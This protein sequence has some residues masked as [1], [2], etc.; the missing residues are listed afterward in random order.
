MDQPSWMAEAWLW[1]G[2]RERPG[3]GDNP[4]VLMFFRD[5]G[6]A[7]IQRDEV[8]WCAAFVGACLERE[9]L[10]G[11]GSLLARSYLDWGQ[12]IDA[13]RLGAIVVLK[14]GHNPSAGH[15]G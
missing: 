6:R 2:T 1:L 14:R 4:N 7:D 8:P 15:V 10:A 5:A 3:R 9:G 13:P 12:A 11:T